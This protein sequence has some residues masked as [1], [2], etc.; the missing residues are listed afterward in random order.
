MPPV[1]AEA[2]G[3]TKVYIFNRND[4]MQHPFKTVVKHM[5]QNDSSAQVLCQLDECSC[6]THTRSSNLFPSI[7]S[8][9]RHPF[10]YG[11]PE[12]LFLAS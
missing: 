6:L 11:V 1:K 8:G 2:Q 12:P 3:Y 7:L 10:E 9:T 4:D 5:C